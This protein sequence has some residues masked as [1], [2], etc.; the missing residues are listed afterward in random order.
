MMYH[1]ALLFNDP[2]IAAQILDAQG[3]RAQRALGR[4]VH[5]FT[6]EAWAAN[7]SRIVENGNRL[8]FSQDPELK[9]ILLGTG[10]REIVEV[11]AREPLHVSL[12]FLVFI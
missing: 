2:A 7:R 5:D 6:E 4:K 1:K 11:R 12:S 3:G 8:K 9:Q 10:D